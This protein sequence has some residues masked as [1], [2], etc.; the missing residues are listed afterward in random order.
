MRFVV[1]STES[2]RERHFTASSGKMCIIHR[3]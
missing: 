3:H 1:F 2:R